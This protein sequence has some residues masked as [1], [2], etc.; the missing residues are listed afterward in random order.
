MNPVIQEW[1]NLIVRWA[2][3]I[4]AIMW[5]GD[6]FLFMWLDSQL[7]KPDRD[8]PDA[9]VGELWMAHSGGFYEVV[10]R[11][12]LDALPPKLHWFKWESYTTWITGSLLLIIVYYLGGRAMLVDAASPLSEGQAIHL[13]LGLIAGGVIVYDLLCRTPLVKDGRVF[14]VVG[15]GLIVGTAYE[16]MRVYSPR[17]AFLQ[18]GAMLGTIMASNVFLRIIPAQKHMLAATREGRP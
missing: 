5:I 4:A 13:S 9:V 8:L 2:H 6:S 10:K 16:V 12:S 18:I 14:G 7:R 17:A 1:L 15:L 3:V 11:K